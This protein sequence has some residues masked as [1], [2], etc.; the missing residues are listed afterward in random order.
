MSGFR[1]STLKQGLLGVRK[2][3]LGL[4]EHLS[5][6]RSMSKKPMLF[7][8]DLH[9][10]V[11]RDL[12]QEF[13]SCNFRTIRWSISGSNQFARSIYKI[14]DPVD[15]INAQTWSQLD[16]DLISE[17]ESRYQNFLSKFDGFVVT[18]TPAFSQLYRSF[19]KP[20]LV[21]N[22]TRYEAPYTKDE[23]KW[24]TLDNYLNNGVKTDKVLLVS[25]NVGDADYLKHRTGIESEVVPSLCD[26]TDL[27][28][29]P[30]GTQKVI[31]SRSPELEDYIERFTF[32]EW[33][34]IKKVMGKNYSWNQY[35]QIK[36]VLYIPYNI[37][38]MTLFEL[39]TAGVPVSV[40]SIDFTK[41]LSKSFSGVL[42]ELSY[43]Q[44]NELPV[45]GL[46]NEDP[47]NYL[48]EKFKDWWLARADF[49]NSDLMPNVR[50][51]SG[52]NELMQE[53]SISDLQKDNYHSLIES[54]NDVIRKKRQNLVSRFSSML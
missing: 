11:M 32:G 7:N 48:S 51:I 23:N 8:L 43:F 39:A 45:I 50:V 20:I 12:Q 22:S 46:D 5:S 52:F 34:G 42:S 40:P 29:M 53:P 38:T 37:S 35:L 47:N 44:L 33:L 6:F 15:V 10:S 21:I 2:L 27:H 4:D 30:G 1:K 26:Y 24:K 49:Y 28:W 13:S 18:H 17:F 14:S 19:G 36:E 25:N 31:I 54:R 16:D 3:H 9:I 41:E